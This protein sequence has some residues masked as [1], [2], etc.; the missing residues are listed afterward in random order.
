MHWLFP[1]HS[2]S[3]FG[4][5]GLVAMCVTGIV[6]LLMV[7]TGLWVWWRKRRGERISRERSRARRAAAPAS[8][9]E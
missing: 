2:G 9:G 6:P 1:L 4:Q 3:A 7:L 5:A 8:A